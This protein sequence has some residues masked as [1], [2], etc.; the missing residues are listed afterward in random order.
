[1]SSVTSATNGSPSRWDHDETIDDTLIVESTQKPK[2]EIIYKRMFQEAVYISTLRDVMQED[3]ILR[4]TE[5]TNSL[6][7]ELESKEQELFAAQKR[8]K[9]LEDRK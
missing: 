2:A 9:E 8:I 6:K 4:L 5:E 3:T 1:M 7:R